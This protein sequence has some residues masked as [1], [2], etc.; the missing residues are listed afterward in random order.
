L[1]N[2]NATPQ[3]S[4]PNALNTYTNFMNVTPATLYRDSLHKGTIT[5]VFSGTTGYAG[6]VG[7]YID[8]NR[9]GVFQF[10][11]RVL[12]KTVAATPT[13]AFTAIDTFRVPDTASIGLTGMRVIYMYGTTSVMSPCGTYNYGE[14]EDYLV[15]ISYPPCNGPTNAGTALIS[16]TVICL[17]Y[18]LTLTDTTHEYKRS[19]IVW[20]WQSSIN[21]GFSWNN[22]ANSQGKD[23]IMRIFTQPLKYRMRMICSVT[24]DTT[25]SNEVEAKLA[26]P[27]Q[28]YCYSIALG[29]PNTNQD[30][31]D[32]GAFKIGNFIMNT[33]GPHLL[34]PMAVR[35]RTDYTNVAQTNL[36]ADSTYAV[37]VFHTMRASQHQNAKVTLFIDYD[38][39]LQYDIPRERVLTGYSTANNWFLIGSVTIPHD[40]IITD[41]PTG[42]RVIINED[43]NP[44][45]ASDNGCGTYISGETEDYVVIL[46]NQFSTGVNTASLVR[47]I[48]LYPNPTTGRTLVTFR[49]SIPVKDVQLV[50][51]DLTGRVLSQQS[52]DGSS[53][54]VRAEVDL[55]GQARGVYFVEVRANGEK[56]VKKLVVQ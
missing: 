1:N 27:Y 17:G 19:G 13:P 38:N 20:N 35:Q 22:V 49:T 26:L 42:M 45:S 41:L 54:Q 31:T 10:N 9:D 7:V 43:M 55:T 37:N 18:T 46:R 23:T 51:T 39:D 3:L 56:L 15:N 21:G 12:Y 28:C 11:E 36:W 34:N 32:I 29:N 16:D 30:S 40:S 33:G 50:V 24:G 47:D 6:L 25:Y 52:Y 4:N 48:A 8:Y 14:T 5:S 53:T 44:N 2:G